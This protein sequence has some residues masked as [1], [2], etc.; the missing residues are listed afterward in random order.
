[1]TAKSPRKKKPLTRDRILDAAQALITKKGLPAFSMR[2]LGTAL[3][4]EA[5]SLYHHFPSKAHLLD[6]LLDRHIA[7]I[8]LPDAS[9]PFRERLLGFAYSYREAMRAF[10]EFAFFMMFHRMN[11]PTCLAFLERVVAIF[12]DAGFD[13]EAGSRAFRSFGYYV[14]G[15][16]LDET[17]GYARGPTAAEPVP[18]DAQLELAPSLLAY[19]RWFGQESWDRTFALGLDALADALDR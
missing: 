3:R 8:E 19:G 16:I 18:L 9:R 10:P 11:T 15:A 1:V 13:D 7:A 14:V 12:R 17:A 5:M 2:T 4:V 6:A